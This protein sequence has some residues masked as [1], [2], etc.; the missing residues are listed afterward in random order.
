M[1]TWSSVISKYITRRSKSHA[2]NHL[3]VFCM[4]FGGFS[5]C[6]S[7]CSNGLKPPT[8]ICICILPVEM[9][10]DVGETG[11]AQAPFEAKIEMQAF[12]G[13]N[14]ERLIFDGSQRSETS[15]EG[16]YLVPGGAVG[17]WSCVPTGNTCFGW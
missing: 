15:D 11:W 3:V 8:N 2:L 13:V 14:N 16:V 17:A 6:D 4:P 1:K 9:R 12:T 5:H 10:T 7:Y